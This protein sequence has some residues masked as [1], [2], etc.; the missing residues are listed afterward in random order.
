M[1]FVGLTQEEVQEKISNQ[2]VNTL[3]KPEIKTNGQIIRQHVFTFFNLYSII[4]A[5]ALLYVKAYSSLFFIFVM[6]TNTVMFIIQE[7][8]SRNLISELNIIISPKT[9]VLR[10]GQLIEIDNEDIVLD[11]IVYYESGNQIS[12]D[13]TIIDGF[14]EVNESLLS[15]EV[16]AI[17][18]HEGDP[19]LSGSFIISGG[20]YAKTIHVG[21]DN[22]AVKITQAVKTDRESNSELLKTF[23]KI[24]RYTSLFVIPIGSILLYQG[25]IVR[26]QTLKSVFV[27]TSSALLGMLPQGL[28]LLTTLSLIASALKLGSK[29][30]LI[31]DLYAIE[32]LSQSDVL[33]LDKTGTLTHGEMTL[34]S[35][36]EYDPRFE[37]YIQTYVNFTH[38][39]NATALA[40]KKAFTGNTRLNVVQEIPF[41]SA[42][43]WSA[44]NLD[45][46]TSLILG[47]PEVLA[48]DLDLPSSMSLERSNGSRIILAGLSTETI[49]LNYSPN[50]LT[51]LAFIAI[52]D[53]LRD[54]AANAINFF[55]ENDVAIKIISGDSVETVQAIASQ[56]NVPN[57]NHTVDAR[58]L[59]TDEEIEHAIL[60]YSVFG[61]A[62]PNQKLR[63]VEA[64]Q[65]NKKKV[66]MTGDGINDVLALKKA[67]CSIAMGEGSDA[68]LQISQ[69]VIM[70]G[71]LSTLV[72][73][74]KE[75]RQVMNHITRSAS[76]YYLRTILTFFV[77]FIAIMMNVPFPFIPF[78][79]TLTNM[80]VDGFPSFML[81]FEQN[82]DKPKESLFMHVFR[83]S[84]PN[85]AAIIFFWFIL[86]VFNQ[87]FNLDVESSQTMM[88][89][90]NG[91]ISIHMIYRIYK[92]LNLYRVAVLII[93]F[94]GFL[95]SSLI[96]WPLLEL[97]RLNFYHIKLML[98]FV[99][100]SH[101]IVYCVH[102]I[103]KSIIKRSNSSKNN[104]FSEA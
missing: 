66:A 58:T 56:A 8:R 86:N 12:A 50:N 40:L 41:S 52:Q 24:T 22:Y 104:N 20:C 5:S 11:D 30:T 59:T 65:R 98:V 91:Y 102:Q 21:A 31:Q 25:L 57:A 97:E 73:V 75:G 100:V 53:P 16:D 82:I 63:F 42:R 13:A 38:D 85:A 43:K 92:P 27:N 77:S 74:V 84:V 96:F 89:F 9:K 95:L 36:H 45:N 68:A 93:D 90:L 76:M 94:V 70:D 32:I 48:N 2:H 23:K 101:L 61:R 39:N 79:I 17:E 1:K 88:Y 99:A 34:K 15:G 33:C 72:D 60:N 19:L 10:D 44:L 87:T 47:A 7:I 28:V 35:V 69:V 46:N 55:T 81:L 83:H 67:D 37:E 29:K 49:D 78:Q 62:T 6:F 64:L 4:I 103:V 14:V 71:Q 54:D 80:F 26:E 3:P 51:P 18:K